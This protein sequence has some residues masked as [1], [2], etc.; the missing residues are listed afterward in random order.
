MG[1]DALIEWMESLLDPLEAAGDP[2]RFFHATYLR[3]TRAVRDALRDGLFADPDWVERWDV[4]FADLYLQALTARPGGPGPGGA[5]PPAGP[6]EVAFRAAREHPGLPPLRHVLLGINAHV[7]FD[8]P[9]ALLEVISAAEFADPALIAQRRADHERIDEV[10]ARRVGAE[11]SELGQLG[12]RSRAD[13]LLGPAN[14]AATRRFLRE[15]RAKVWANTLELNAA[16]TLGPA[17]YAERLGD[18]ESLSAEKVEDLLRPGQVLL[19]LAAQGFG[20]RLVS[21]PGPRPAR[22]RKALAPPPGTPGRLRSFDPAQVADLE[23]RAWVGYYRRDWA[24]VLRASVG[25]VR[26]GFGMSLPR[27]LYGAWLVLRANQLW[28]PADNDP[29]GARRCMERFYALIRTAY[30]Q[31]RD[32]AE[33][34]RLEVEWWR[35]HREHQRGTGDAD[36]LVTAVTRLYAFLYGE[37]EEAVRPAAAQRVL[38]M[39]LSDQWVTEGCLPGS[40]LLPQEHAA[41][42]R[43]YAALLAAVHHCSRP[44]PGPPVHSLIAGAPLRLGPGPGRERGG[45]LCAVVHLMTGLR[46]A[47]QAHEPLLGRDEQRH[48]RDHIVP[49]LLDAGH[50]GFLL[51]GQLVRPGLEPLR[52]LLPGTDLPAHQVPCPGHVHS[53]TYRGD[54]PAC[55]RPREAPD[56]GQQDVHPLTRLGRDRRRRGPPGRAF[57]PK[58]TP[59]EPLHGASGAVLLVMPLL[60]VIVGRS[61]VVF[62]RPVAVIRR[63]GAFSRRVRR[64][65]RAPSIYARRKQGKRGRPQSAAPGTGPAGTILGGTI[66]RGTMIWAGPAGQ[67]M[68]S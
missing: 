59:W 33:A 32:V 35:L 43:S 42:V 62:A 14:Q 7:N 41:L 40:P 27:T 28:A 37:P 50:P 39:D 11:D 30:G 65:P 57:P 54:A 5:G 12:P 55:N 49:A 20:V 63:P 36:P 16:R 53:G 56:Q 19:R 1:I 29:D 51:L 38:A 4:A 64:R 13:A 10:L 3:T 21:G 68:G 47:A 44:R 2:R 22:A 31:P 17:E 9:Q 61:V 48:H 23:F 25:L 6:W 26:A 66:L 15:A 8:L 24:D 34:A 46:G 67:P 58:R 45:Q 60:L 52:L 18:L